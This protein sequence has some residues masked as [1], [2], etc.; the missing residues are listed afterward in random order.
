[1]NANSRKV[2]SEVLLWLSL[3]ALASA[4]ASERARGATAPLI[5]TLIAQVAVRIILVTWVYADAQSRGRG[6]CYDYDT[7]V[8]F[9][10]P[11]VVPYYLFQTR[12][13]RAFLTMLYFTCLCVAA[14]LF[15]LG[16]YGLLWILNR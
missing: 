1:M 12:G 11:V 16:V 8:F 9:A 15:G 13:A 10:W 3:A 6:L 5:G 7:F 2:V 14:G 4:A